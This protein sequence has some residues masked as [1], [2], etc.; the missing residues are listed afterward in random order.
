[1]AN[2]LVVEDEVELLQVIK[3]KLMKEGHSV[4][5]AETGTAALQILDEHSPDLIVLDVM[6]PEM[7]GWEV[8]WRIRQTSAVPIIIVTAKVEDR[9]VIRGLKLGADEYVTKPFELGTLMARVEALLR[10]L[11]W[12]R[13]GVEKEANALKKSITSMVSHEL[14]TPLAAMMGTLDL[15]LQ[16]A[17]KDDL[18]TQQEFIRNAR[19]NA[20]AMRWLVDDLL[21]LVRIDQGLKIFRRPLVIQDELKRLFDLMNGQLM[22]QNLDASYSCPNDLSAAIDQVLFRRALHHLFANAIKFSPEGGQVSVVAE[23]LPGGGVGV[24]FHDQGPGIAPEFHEKIFERFFQIDK[25]SHRKY[26]GLGIGL[27]IGREIAHAHGGDITLQSALGQGSI[28]FL[29]IPPGKSDWNL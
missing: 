14:R 17:F 5:T 21:I 20:L 10:R 13:D 8:C 29:T 25:G 16:K 11:K 12:E 6:M 22:Q 23:Q 2:I 1:M 18:A 26:G 7:S 24:K 15:A 27:S 9:D 19:Q 4:Y 3:L 28:F